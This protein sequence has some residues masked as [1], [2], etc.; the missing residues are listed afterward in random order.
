MRDVELNYLKPDMRPPFVMNDVSGISFI[1]LSAQREG[2]VPLFVFKD[3]F[4][5]RHSPV[6]AG[7]GPTTGTRRGQQ[8]L[9]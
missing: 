8:A 3:G 2:D 5:I 4:G 7:A 9:G 1:N 6:V